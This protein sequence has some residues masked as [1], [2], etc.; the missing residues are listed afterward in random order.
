MN[1]PSGRSKLS[2][3]NR[4]KQILLHAFLVIRRTLQLAEHGCLE[5]SINAD[6]SGSGVDVKVDIGIGVKIYT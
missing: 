5:S 6:I 3:Y 2:N 1:K 4:C